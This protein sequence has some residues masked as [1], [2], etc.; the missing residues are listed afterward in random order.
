ML[1]KLQSAETLLS[2]TFP[3]SKLFSMLSE[4]LI[5]LGRLRELRVDIF[6]LPGE[7]LDVLDELL[8]FSGLSLGELDLFIEL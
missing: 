5:G 7:C 8:D 6:V 2:S 3:V 4:V 1:F